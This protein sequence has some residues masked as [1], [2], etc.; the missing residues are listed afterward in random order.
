MATVT[1]SEPGKQ[2]ITAT[3]HNR[4]FVLTGEDLATYYR[5]NADPKGTLTLLSASGA[6][7]AKVALH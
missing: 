1:L 4:T 3:V 5:P 6:V 2:T 7:V